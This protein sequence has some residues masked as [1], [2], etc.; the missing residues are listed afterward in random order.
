MF[1]VVG[2][3]LLAIGFII[4][5]HNIIFK[6]LPK[7]IG[8]IAVF[9]ISGLLFF[10]KTVHGIWLGFTILIFGFIWLKYFVKK[11]VKVK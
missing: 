4:V 5:F 7:V 6:K 8:Y 3:F 9:F 2:T 11:S 1:L 10:T